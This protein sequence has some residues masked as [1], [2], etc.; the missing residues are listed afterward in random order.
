MQGLV[1]LVRSP[2]GGWNAFLA[3]P[4]LLPSGPAMPRRNRCL[5]VDPDLP[6]CW[7]VS[8][9]CARALF[10]LEPEAGDAAEDEE[11]FHRKE[12][13]LARLEVLVAVFSIEVLAYSVMGNHLHL[14]LRNVPEVGHGWSAQEVLERW[15]TLHPLRNRQGLRE[16]EPGELE[17]LLADEA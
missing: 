4:H 13:L 5:L 8:N 16:P 7:H 14:V 6:Q 12:L 2:Y 9:R 1:L 10:L 11:P 15:L 17:A 3:L